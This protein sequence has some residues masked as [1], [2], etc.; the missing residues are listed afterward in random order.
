[1]SSTI[2]IARAGSRRCRSSDR[3]PTR[4]HV[5]TGSPRDA[6]PALLP[7]G[8]P[9][10]RASAVGRSRAR[11]AGRG[12]RRLPGGEPVDRPGSRTRGGGARPRLC[13]LPRVR[14]H[15]SPIPTPLGRRRPPRSPVVGRGPLSRGPA[16]D[17]PPGCPR[18]RAAPTRRRDADRRQHP[19]PPPRR[20]IRPRRE[21]APGARD[22]RLVVDA[23]AVRCDRPPRGP[24]RAAG[25]AI[26]RVLVRR[27]LPVGH[28]GSRP[29]RPGDVRERARRADDLPGPGNLYR[30]CARPGE[31]DGY[32]RAACVRPAGRARSRA[33]S[34]RSSRSQRRYRRR[35]T[36]RSSVRR[37]GARVG[38]R[39]RS[40]RSPGGA[41]RR[42]SWRRTSGR[43]APRR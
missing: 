1:M 30:L 9:L 6:Q 27:R 2:P 14:D 20:T 10:A 38:P 8:R 15:P 21:V 19:S 29:R 5:H 17:S 28:E 22:R 35:P 43:V 34:E 3:S 36:R 42:R 24:E 7:A 41:R 16:A 40:H 32:R 25:R 33:L 13:G 23:A 11:E 37:G 26:R 39:S 31:L 4:R 12:H 18:A